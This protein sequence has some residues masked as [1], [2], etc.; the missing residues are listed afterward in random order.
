VTIEGELNYRF[1]TDAIAHMLHSHGCFLRSLEE[2]RRV[3]ISRVRLLGADDC[4]ACQ[5]ADHRTFA[6][7]AVPELPLADCT[8]AG[9]Y[10]CRVIVIA[11]AN[12]I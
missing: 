3:G 6:V 8:C 4:A 9:R 1:G 11:D 12:T 7:D 10:G 5:A 2:F